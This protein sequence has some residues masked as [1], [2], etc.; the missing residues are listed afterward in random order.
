MDKIFLGIDVGTNSVRVGAFNQ[1][2]QLRAK[3]EHPIRIWRPRPDFV[4]QSSE[5]IWSA[6]SKATRACLTNGG[7]D[8]TSVK[9][10]SFDATCSLVA[11][12][13]E[14][15]PISVSPTKRPD[16]GYRASREDQPHG[17]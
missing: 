7:I 17:P 1:K 3:G 5:D 10:L 6:F 15:R 11:L 12:G 4:E 13:K 14:F 2:G 16:Q 9:G 8:P